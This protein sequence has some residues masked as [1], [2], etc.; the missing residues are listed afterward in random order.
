MKENGSKETE[1]DNRKRKSIKQWFFILKEWW[2]KEQSHETV[3]MKEKDKCCQ[4]MC[5]K[6][7]WGTI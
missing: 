2:P 3:K 4:K 6:G 5:L 1:R 7:K